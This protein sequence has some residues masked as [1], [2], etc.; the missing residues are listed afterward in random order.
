MWLKLLTRLGR[1]AYA[2]PLAWAAAVLLMFISEISYRSSTDA[3]H[4]LATMA[5]AR[6]EIQSLWRYL[7]D[8]ETGQRGYLLTGRDVY[9]KPYRDA[10]THVDT[11]LHRLLD[12]YRLDPQGHPLVEQLGVL[13]TQKL[14]ELATTMHMYDEGPP[15][16]WRDM[17][18]TDIGQE[19]MEAIRAVSHTL[20][21]LESQRVVHK[22][23][24]VQRTLL[25]NRI[26]V[27]LTTLI[28]LLAASLYFRQSLMLHQAQADQ[29][30][31]EQTER[32]RLEVEVKTR[33]SQLT[34][35]AKHL[36]TAREDE[37]S[38]IA[39]EL[40][41]ELG[42]LL[43]AAKLDAAR[44]RARLDPMTPEV[45]ERLAHLNKLLN[46][47]IALKR[48]IIEN[49]RPSSLSNL[50][51]IAALE[52]ITSEFAQTSG[53]QMHLMLLPV[54]LSSSGELTV[55]RLVQEALTNIAK[56]AHATEVWIELS[57]YQGTVRV[58]VR[59]NGCGFD[60]A[61][62]RHAAHGL[63]GMRYRVE[64]EGGLMTLGSQPG[65]GTTIEV[66]LPRQT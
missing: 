11:S 25:I 17:M 59:D 19:K 13:S 15:G 36:Q 20:L 29:R 14:S 6:T 55:Y 50:G 21:D 27:A 23:E 12:Y 5:M 52:I 9:L 42:A 33:T 66:R 62:P 45:S 38:H 37:R 26:G 16:A 18:L 28:S 39:R 64:A 44:L 35:L 32:D 3:L 46:D 47:G 34:E 56:Y 22:R 63:L 1:S 51:L 61:T 54:T 60:T 4:Q 8:A 65:A 40:H 57:Q 43:T 53:I 2:L 31:A 30:L 7:V 58:A 48:Q 24:G 10:R 41:D 49:L